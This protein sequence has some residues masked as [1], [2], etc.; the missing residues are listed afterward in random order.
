MAP[1]PGT[2]CVAFLAQGSIGEQVLF[3]DLNV[4][5]ICEKDAS[6]QLR[7]PRPGLSGFALPGFVFRDDFEDGQ[8]NEQIWNEI[9][10]GEV[11]R[12]QTGQGSTASFFETETSISSVPLDLSLARHLQFTLGGGACEEH[13]K[14]QLVFGTALAEAGEY[15]PVKGMQNIHFVDIGPEVPAPRAVVSAYTSSQD[16]LSSGSGGGSGGGS[17]DAVT[18]DPHADDPLAGLVL[19]TE[20]ASWE[21]AHSYSPSGSGEVHLQVIPLRFRRPGVCVGWRSAPIGGN[22][23]VCWSLDDVALANHESSSEPI[24]DDFDPVDPSN[25]FFFPGA[26][27]KES[28]SSEG[29]GLVFEGA[30]E[31]SWASTR[32]LDLSF[33]PLEEDVV[34]RQDFADFVPPRRLISPPPSQVGGVGR[35]GGQVRQ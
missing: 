17:P 34:L 8:L 25:W 24:S 15:I 32:L 18:F 4:L 16:D 26:S 35:A 13:A 20:C 11:R 6:A 33:A 23:S 27:V 30:G 22:T 12:G 3:K 7:A 19:G 29:N 5:E 9:R 21:E 31:V 10:G 1:P 2:G 14:I 28:C